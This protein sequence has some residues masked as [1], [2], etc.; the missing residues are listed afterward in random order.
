MP[1]PSAGWSSTF[2]SLL[3]LVRDFA[4]DHPGQT[5]VLIDRVTFSAAAN[6]ATEIEQRT[7]AVFIGEPMGGG[8]NFW[9]DV[10]WVRLDHLPVPMQVGISTRYWQFAEPDDARLTIEPD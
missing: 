1:A 9:D 4:A 8:L 2:G 6:L 3:E 10:T 7:D 5:W